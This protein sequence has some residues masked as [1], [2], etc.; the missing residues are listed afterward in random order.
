MTPAITLTQA[1]NDPALFGG[2][3]AAPSFWTW[4]VVAKVIDGL[5][6]TEPR[7]VE[8]FKQC[9]GR[10]QLPVGPVRRII[11]LTG[12]R[13]GKDRFLSSVA[14]WRAA[15]GA[16]WR[17]YI[18]A[19][20]KVRSAFCS[21]PISKQAQILRRYCEGLLQ[22]PLLRQEIV[23]QT[24]EVTEF[25]NGASLEIST[26]DARLVA[27]PQRHRGAWLRGLATGRPTSSR[28]RV[29]RRWSAPPSRA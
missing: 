16:D 24:G 25:R 26:N 14:V 27:W 8:L 7:E 29:T 19:P 23:R 12:R 15:L 18:S 17:K 22:A 1:L 28:R 9:T 6:L 5:P 21:V 13:G 11:N 2:T 20:A 10:T 4:K 3:F